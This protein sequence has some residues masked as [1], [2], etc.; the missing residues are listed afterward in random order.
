F[1]GFLH[2]LFPMIT[3]RMYNEKAAMITFWLLFVGVSMVFLTQ[4]LLGLYGQPRRVF[5][6][7][8]VQPLIIMNQISTVGAWISAAGAAIFI[9]NMIISAMRGKPADMK[10]PFQLGEQYYDYTRREPHH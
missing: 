9:S 1:L 7:I 8:P 5:D 6:Y 4:H 2:Y 10:D 3:G